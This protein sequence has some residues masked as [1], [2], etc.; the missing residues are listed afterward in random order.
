MGGIASFAGY[1]FLAHRA[2]LIKL[3]AGHG[4]HPLQIPFGVER[5]DPVFAVGQRHASRLHALG[6]GIT[7]GLRG[8][9]FVGD[10]FDHGGIGML[11]GGHGRLV[12]QAAGADQQGAFGQRVQEFA[13]ALAERA[14]AS[15]AGDG[16]LRDRVHEH[17]DH[18][19][20]LHVVVPQELQRLREAVIHQHAARY[21][22][23]EV[24]VHQMAR[25]C[26]RLVLG[27]VQRACGREIVAH[28]GGLGADAKRRHQLVEEAVVMVG[29]D[30][31]D[32][33]GCELMHEGARRANG[34][35][36]RHLVFVV[37]RVQSEQ[38]RMRH[39]KKCAA[40]AA[41]VGNV[42]T[43]ACT[44]LRACKTCAMR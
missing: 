37:D 15:Q 6:F 10:E 23:V 19:R 33:F 32:E 17:R 16:G 22:D 12:R 9:A 28:G 4:L 3:A 7:L 44:S 20:R 14:A 25:Q 18:R 40:C 43:H 24:V 26:Q 13:D 30:Q 11:H 5:L 21:R 36:K 42:G 39:A 35:V 29:A 31:H 2:Q 41:C 34:R 38:R 1:G 8:Q 27:N